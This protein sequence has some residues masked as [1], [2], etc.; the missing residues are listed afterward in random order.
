MSL[1]VRV[2]VCVYVCVCVYVLSTLMPD[3]SG[4]H[5]QVQRPE[6]ATRHLP[7]THAAYHMHA[8]RHARR[9]THRMVRSQ[10]ATTVGSWERCGRGEA[11]ESCG[12]GQ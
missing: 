12:G 11:V 9:P 10:H 6:A 2:R 8:T 3:M 1:G 5:A 4:V 7:V